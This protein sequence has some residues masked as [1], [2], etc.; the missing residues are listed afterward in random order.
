MIGPSDLVHLAKRWWLAVAGPD[1]TPEQ[2]L[3]AVAFLTGSERELWW[4][5]SPQDRSHAVLV[6]Q[7]FM[8]ARPDATRSEMAAALLHDVGKIATQLGTWDRVAATVVPLWVIPRIGSG[9]ALRDRWQT[10]R[11]HERIGIEMLE[12]IGSDI[13]T[14]TLL[15]GCGPAVADLAQAD[16]I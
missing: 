10:Y 13:E 6:A 12:S 5:M 3:W 7:R 8:A 14:I 11:D 15:R 4:Q 16:R 1:P 9:A 2:D